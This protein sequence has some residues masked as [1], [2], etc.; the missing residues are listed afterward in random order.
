MEKKNCFICK[1]QSRVVGA[2]GIFSYYVECPHCGKYYIEND[3]VDYNDLSL[4]TRSCLLYYLTQKWQN[5][6]LIP[7]FHG[8]DNWEEGKVEGQSR[9]TISI[10]SILNLYPKNISEKIDMILLNLSKRLRY[11]GDFFNILNREK[12]YVDFFIDDS[13]E[14]SSEKQFIELIYTLKELGY[15]KNSQSAAVKQNSYTLTAKAWDKIYD[16]QSK[17]K[18]LP[19]AF[20]AMWFDDCMHNAKEKIKKAIEDSNYIPIIISDK[21]HNNQIV[22]EI[23]YEI[24]QSAFVVA[25][26]TGHRNGVYYEAGYAQALGKEVIMTC[27]ED[28]FENRHFDVAQISMIKWKNEEDLYKRLCKRIKSTVGI[29][30]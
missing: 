25:D 26:L 28:D 5:K 2:P 9:Y 3:I 4:K 24:K 20:V 12:L 15:L 7:H 23:F 29:R 1:E 17:N 13:F 6:N 30:E 18:I 8:N 27:K 21:Q 22:P 11:I 16:L 14:S 10:D 19:K